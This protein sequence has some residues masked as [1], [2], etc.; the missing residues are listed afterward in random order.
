MKLIF[1]IILEKDD[2]VT[3]A[4]PILSHDLQVK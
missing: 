3:Y 1:Y 2:N 4:S